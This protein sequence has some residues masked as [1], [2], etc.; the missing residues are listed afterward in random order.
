MSNYSISSILLFCGLPGTLK[1]F[2]ATRLSARLGWVYLP[3]RA[4][5]PLSSDLSGGDLAAE[6]A[7]RY[8][9]A[10]EISAFLVSLGTNVIADGG[11][12]TRQSRRS[13]LASVPQKNRLVIYCRCDDEEIRRRRLSQRASDETDHEH[14]SARVIL[15]HG[16]LETTLPEPPFLDIQSGDVRAV[17]DVDTV[18]GALTWVGEPP[19]ELRETLSAAIG[20]IMAEYSAN[21]LPASYKKML[22]QQFDDLAEKYD[23][24]T[25]WRADPVLLRQITRDLRM[26]PARVLDLGTGTGLA[27]AWYSE[28]GHHTV[29]LDISPAML[30]RGAKRLTLAVLGSALDPPF[31]DDYFDLVIVRQCLHYVEPGLLLAEAFRVLKPGGWLAVSGIVASD[32][33]ARQFWLEFKAVTQP[34]R[35]DFF[36]VERLRHMITRAGFAVQE[37][38]HH[39]VRRVDS[40]SELRDRGVPEPHGGWEAFLQRM[41]RL[42]SSESSASQLEFEDP[43]LSYWQKWITIWASK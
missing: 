31:L 23:G 40:V 35:L 11:Y 7:Q 17:L 14:L 16:A 37:H 21:P 8:T 36:T 24:S 10:A 38:L 2:L 34:L 29:G 27:S 9:R 30:S 13:V 1:T 4:V 19:E 39:Q 18:S 41:V 43:M 33:K 5:G 15:S 6:R 28:Q 25:A 12:P 42:A 3:T 32:E 26:A 22:R 20:S